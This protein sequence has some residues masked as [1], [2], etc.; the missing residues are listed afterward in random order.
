MDKKI[1]TRRMNVLAGHFR[2][3]SRCTM[4]EVRRH[5]DEHDCWVVLHKKVYDVTKF[6]SKH[7]GGVTV[8]LR[9]AGTD[10]TDAFDQLHPPGTLDRCVEE[11]AFVCDIVDEIDA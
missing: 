5:D 8:L 6:I 7:P 1:V 3:P 2:P 11:V 9:V 4:A 10:A